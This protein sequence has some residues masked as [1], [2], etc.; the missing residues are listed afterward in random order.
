MKRYALLFILFI[1]L[2]IPPI[3][4][5][6][7]LFDNIFRDEEREKLLEDSISV[8]RSDILFAIDLIEYLEFQKDSLQR[9]Y[10][11]E[12]KNIKIRTVTQEVTKI[13]KD[14]VTVTQGGFDVNKIYTI[15]FDNTERYVGSVFNIKGVTSFKWDFLNNQPLPPTTTIND[16]QL[17]LNVRTRLKPIQTGIEVQSIPLSPNIMITDN[18]DNVIDESNYLKKIPSKI[19]IGI[20]GGYGFTHQGANPFIGVGVN[21]SLLEAGDAIRRLKGKTPR[22]K[23]Q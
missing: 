4:Y 11:L 21:Y 14:T 6:Q 1:F 12:K 3:S 10:E 7:G 22:N 18:V 8:M 19:S 2:A 20:I 17:R 16:F 5:S 23:K 15:P 9:L 13:V